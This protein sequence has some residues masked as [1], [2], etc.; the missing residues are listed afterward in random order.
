MTDSFNRISYTKRIAQRLYR[1]IN[2]RKSIVVRFWLRLGFFEPCG[3]SDSKLILI[4][5]SSLSG[6]LANR[7]LYF[8]FRIQTMKN[9]EG[10]ALY[11][12]LLD[13]WAKT[14]RS[15]GFFALWKG[16]VPY[17]A[18]IAP[19]TVLL[20]LFVERLTILYKK[21]IMHSSDSTGI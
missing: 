20:F 6:Y 16:F 19:A 10:K 15:E 11:T 3:V 9:K 14:V 18:R 2:N 5:Y 8:V 7:D 1:T 4:K 13:V 12:G 21:N 17:Y